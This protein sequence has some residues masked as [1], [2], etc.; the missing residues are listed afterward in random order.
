[1]KINVKVFSVNQLARLGVEIKVFNQ[2]HKNINKN[3]FKRLFCLNPTLFGDEAVVKLIS[4]NYLLST[5]YKKST[6]LK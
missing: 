2:Q 5:K 6:T 1:M 4:L 3:I